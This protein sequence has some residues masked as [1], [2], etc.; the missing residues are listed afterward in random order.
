VCYKG[1]ILSQSYRAL[2]SF[3]QL[4]TAAK[5]VAGRIAAN[6]RDAAALCLQGEIL[7]DSGDRAK[8][9]D[10]YRQALDIAGETRT[11]LLLRDTLLDGLRTEFAT[12]RSRS[13]E[14]EKLLEN[15]QQRA[16]YL[17]LVT[18][19]LQ[20]A[21]ELD[22]AFDRCQEL[23]A[24]DN[25]RFPME[26]IS[27]KHSVRR[28]RWIQ[29][30]LDSLR[31]SAKDELAARMD[32]TF[33]EK[34]KT[35][36]SEGTQEGLKAFLDYY[37]SLPIGSEVRTAWI[38]QLKK[39]GRP[40]DVEM[41]IMQSQ[42]TLGLPSNGPALAETAEY[43]RQAGQ[44]DAAAACYRWILSRFGD[45]EC[46]E[47]KNGKQLVEALDQGESLRKAIER[48]SDWP[49]G[50]VETTVD[51][52]RENNYYGYYGQ[53]KLEILDNC[54]PFFEGMNFIFDTNNGRKIQCKD[55]TGAVR[56]NYSLADGNDSY[57]QDCWGVRC[58]GHVLLLTSGERLTAIDTLGADKT[59]P[60]KLLWSEDSEPRGDNSNMQTVG[61]GNAKAIMINMQ[62]GGLINSE[63]SA[64]DANFIS[65]RYLCVQRSRTLRA[66][67]TMD[68]QPLWE[69]QGIP[70][71]STIFGDE[72][73]VF[74]LPPNKQEALVFRALDGEP[75][76]T[77]KVDRRE[78]QANSQAPRVVTSEGNVQN[79]FL[80]S[81]GRNLLFWRSKGGRRIPELYDVWEQKSVWTGKGYSSKSRC[82]LINREL[83]GILDSNGKF[84]LLRVPEGRTVVEAQFEP[85]SNLADLYVIPSEDGYLVLTN[86]VPRLSLNS[87]H[88]Q[89]V[90]NQS[91]VQINRGRLYG[92][93]RNGKLLWPHPVKISNQYL[94]YQPQEYP[95]LTFA[96]LV[97]EQSNNQGRFKMALQMI[98]KRTGRVVYDNKD[99]PE[100]HFLHVNADASKKTLQLLMQ[101]KSL[102]FSF[103]DKAWPTAEEVEKAKTEEKEKKPKK[104][105]F[106][107]MKKAAEDSIK[108]QRF[109]P[110]ISEE[111]DE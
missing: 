66:L 37:G 62:R 33:A 96:A 107:A 46:R 18:T 106:K 73:Y 22:A 41:A 68:G 59:H 56:W 61:W 49:T 101:S 15:S 29:A 26:P 21:G 5:D 72:D 78:N 4:D 2:D 85:E 8:A 91:D 10:C 7:L 28:D 36:L 35:A 25:G 23:I 104:S 34:K 53:R 6:P 97:Y 71:A 93:D 102:T 13:D 50:K 67:N 81:Y 86:S 48:H 80:A 57:D 89:A 47:G 74:V 27:K 111:L 40:L 84:T 55:S 14:I 11:K 42:R 52:K 63:F 31:A 65:N 51:S 39:I 92:V 79:D 60:P 75:L 100:S 58:W 76:G 69:R 77:R 30:R 108:P 9:I 110:G 99:M 87:V 98:D 70:L 43:F 12:Y 95:V 105:I 88:T 83:L 109:V 19:G 24:L 3:Y 103:T 90:G 94:S 45:Q 1:R 64:G 54:G 16:T 32:T 82:A 20:A 17:Q 38:E 44:E